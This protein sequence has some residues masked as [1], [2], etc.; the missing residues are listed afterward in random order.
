LNYLSLIDNTKYS[1]LLEALD[2]AQELVGQYKGGYSDHFLS[3]EEFHEALVDSISKLRAGN[4]NELTKLYLWFA[5]SYDWDDFVRGDG[6]DLGNKIFALL[7]EMTKSTKSENIISLIRDYQH[8]VEF[9]MTA[10]IKKFDRNDLLTAYR[11]DHI[12]PQVGEIKEFG[13]T[14]YAFHGIGLRVD[15]DD[16][17]SV[18]FDFA[19]IP[20]QRHDGFDVWRLS[21]FV[22]SRTIKYSKYLDNRELEKDFNE[23]ITRGTIF[24]PDVSLQT[25]LYFFVDIRKTN[26]QNKKP[27][28]KIWN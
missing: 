7:S 9:V 6:I 24:N 10:F 19:F 13:I 28:W 16:N 23:L 26:K 3:A 2:I 5:P 17:T 14:R 4:T 27:W 18:D 15:F 22:K 12:Y 20:E 1:K 25:N 8:S 11:H 21:E